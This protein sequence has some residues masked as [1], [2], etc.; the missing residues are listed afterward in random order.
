ML[1]VESTIN[2]RGFQTEAVLSVKN[3]TVFIRRLHGCFYTA[4]VKP[5]SMAW[6]CLVLRNEIRYTD[7]GKC[8]AEMV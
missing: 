3:K 7:G 8:R 4:S 5:F 6:I 1:F 2:F